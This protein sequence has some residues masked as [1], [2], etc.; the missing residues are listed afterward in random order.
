MSQLLIERSINMHID[1]LRLLEEEGCCFCV[2]N[3]HSLDKMDQRR[4]TQSSNSRKR[5]GT[6]PHSPQGLD[7]CFLQ[8]QSSGTN[9]L[10]GYAGDFGEGGLVVG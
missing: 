3:Q 6:N 7:V 9:D 5:S 4:L 1:D 2:S 8:T 10:G